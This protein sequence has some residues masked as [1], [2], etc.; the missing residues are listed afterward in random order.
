MFGEINNPFPNELA[1]IEFLDLNSMN[2]NVLESINL[3]YVND[4]AQAPNLT[5]NSNV[6]GTYIVKLSA[7]S[8]GKK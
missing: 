4:T 8:N 1:H 6:P 3:P 5:F 7:D 2:F